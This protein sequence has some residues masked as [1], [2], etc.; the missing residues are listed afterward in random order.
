[1]KPANTQ[2]S[3]SLLKAW[4]SLIL[5]SVQIHFTRA[6]SYPQE[7]EANQVHKLPTVV[8][9]TEAWAVSSDHMC[10]GTPATERLRD[11]ELRPVRPGRRLL[12]RVSFQINLGLT[13]E[14]SAS[15]WKFPNF[16]KQKHYLWAAMGSVQFLRRSDPPPSLTTPPPWSLL[17]HPLNVHVHHAE[18]GVFVA[19]QEL[20]YQWK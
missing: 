13:F 15:N 1:M 17:L 6:H 12:C 19:H 9:N 3:H 5:P 8:S 14:K 20:E 18:Y 7:L 16:N 2:C 4:V 10:Q 11:D